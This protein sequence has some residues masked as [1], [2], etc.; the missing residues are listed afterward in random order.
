MEILVQVAEQGSFS[1]AAA[2]LRMAQPSVSARVAALEASLGVR[3][4]NRGHRWVVVTPAGS[5]L[6]PYARRCRETGGRGHRRHADRAGRL[7][8]CAWARPPRGWSSSS[9]RCSPGCLRNTWR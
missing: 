5:A 6:L 8:A 3:L 9:P 7:P 1:R 2:A 4:F